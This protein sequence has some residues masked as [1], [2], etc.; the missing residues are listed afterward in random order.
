MGTRQIGSRPVL[1][2]IRE[3]MA[4][5]QISKPF[6]RPG[7]STRRRSTAGGFWPTRTRPASAWRAGTARISPDASR[8]SAAVAELKART[9]VLDGE[10]AVFDSDLL[11]RF[12]WIQSGRQRNCYAHISTRRRREKL[13]EYLK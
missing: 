10:L 12:E 8:S 1:P 4:A 7:G 11:S 13:A 9:L 5:T 3:P 6:H 2:K